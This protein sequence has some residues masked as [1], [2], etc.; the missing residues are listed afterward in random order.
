MGASRARGTGDEAG[1]RVGSSGSRE[2]GF[3]AAMAVKAERNS[4]RVAVFAF[5]LASTAAW[6][7]A[8]VALLKVFARFL[9]GGAGC[10]ETVGGVDTGNGDAGDSATGGGDAVDAG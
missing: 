2:Q 7:L 4:G 3:S 6:L 1:C 9:D 8:R 5:F 10:G